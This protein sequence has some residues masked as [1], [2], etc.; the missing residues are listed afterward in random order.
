MDWHEDA[1]LDLLTRHMSPHDNLTVLCRD[2][3]SVAPGP[4]GQPGT[5][6]ESH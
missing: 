5:M 4:S 1:Y 2:L 6:L 3:N